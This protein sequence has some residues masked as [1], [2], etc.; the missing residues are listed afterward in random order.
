MSSKEDEYGSRECYEKGL[1]WIRTINPNG[2][3]V[4]RISDY[5]TTLEAER[6][7]LRKRCKY[8]LDPGAQITCWDE[9]ERVVRE[10]EEALALARLWEDRARIGNERREI[11]DLSHT[12]SWKDEEGFVGE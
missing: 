11:K 8:N 5:V 10:R 3:I 6:D 2:T 9:F 1:N 4:D 7:M 12:I